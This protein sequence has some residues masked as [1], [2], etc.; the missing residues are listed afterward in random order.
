MQPQEPMLM[1]IQGTQIFDAEE[2]D[3]W[4]VIVPI[5]EGGANL[6]QTLDNLSP[7]NVDKK[8]ASYVT[9][10]SNKRKASNNKT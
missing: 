3:E 5:E 9:R 8:K 7:P 2:E 6:S 4:N 10:G 1:V